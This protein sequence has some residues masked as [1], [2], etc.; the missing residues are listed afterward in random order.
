MNYVEEVLKVFRN[1]IFR[2]V[3]YLTSG[4]LVFSSMYVIWFLDEIKLFKDS[5]IQSKP[6]IF[7]L[8]MSII[9]LTYAFGYGLQELFSVLRIISTR[10]NKPKCKLMIWILSNFFAGADSQWT[11]MLD[12]K[13]V[14]ILEIWGKRDKIKNESK[15][16]RI[17]RA[18][19]LMHIGTALTPGI[20]I[21]FLIIFIK[22]IF[23]FSVFYLLLSI[24]SFAFFLIMLL[25]SK[26]KNYELSLIL[27][28][29]IK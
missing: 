2:D 9:L 5:D 29:I 8:Y 14:S 17:N 13:K 24:F 21:T 11:D 26:I 6:I 12:R 22:L 7:V 19:N 28:E 16:S 10:Y 20:M 15:K 23:D 4:T 3:M 25:V 1:F 27:Y 18:V